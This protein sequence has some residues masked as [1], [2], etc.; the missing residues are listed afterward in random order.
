MKDPVAGLRTVFEHPGPRLVTGVPVQWPC[1]YQRS[2]VTSAVYFAQLAGIASVPCRMLV[3]QPQMQ[4]YVDEVLRMPWPRWRVGPQWPVRVKVVPGYDRA[5]Y[6]SGTLCVPPR[7]EELIVLHE[8]AHHLAPV[9]T[10]HHGTLVPEH[11]GDRFVSAYLDLIEHVMNP[12][13]AD[14][15]RECFTTEGVLT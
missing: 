11:H 4:E 8:L 10:G 3:G 6:G 13:A 9:T 7:V 1:R 14:R 12:A 5:S 15:F 2:D